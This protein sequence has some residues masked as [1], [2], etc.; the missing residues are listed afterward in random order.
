MTTE[1]AKTILVEVESLAGRERTLAKHPE[2]F[3]V[4]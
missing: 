2:L 1:C 4:T 3:H